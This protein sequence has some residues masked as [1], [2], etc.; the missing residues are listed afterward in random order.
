MEIADGSWVE[1]RDWVRDVFDPGLFHI[2]ARRGL[3]VTVRL[4]LDQVGYVQ[5][6][7]I[8]PHGG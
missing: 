3:V 2:L 1:R 5:L 7:R 8:G 6:V 4:V